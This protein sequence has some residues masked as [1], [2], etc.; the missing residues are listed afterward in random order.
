MK[1]IFLVPVI[2]LAII[3]SVLGVT[4]HLSGNDNWQGSSLNGNVDIKVYQWCDI[5]LQYSIHAPGYVDTMK[6]YDYKELYDATVTGVNNDDDTYIA[7]LLHVRSN[8]NLKLA[9]VGFDIIRYTNGS[10]ESKNEYNSYIEKKEWN[11]Y[12]WRPSGDFE[13]CDYGWKKVCDTVNDVREDDM[14]EIEKDN[15]KYS[16]DG[17]DIGIGLR[18]GVTK[19]FP[20]GKY[21]FKYYIYVFPTVTFPS[22]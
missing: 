1:F 10:T 15:I 18:L 3:S 22:G 20:A 6:I 12:R 9:M 19:D 13:E 21:D 16:F 2:V 8:A 11:I 17:A 5:T 4:V 14:F 7:A